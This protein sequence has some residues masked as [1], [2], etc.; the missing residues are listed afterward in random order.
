[1]YNFTYFKIEAPDSILKQD[2]SG[3]CFWGEGTI[4]LIFLSLKS[5]LLKFRLLC[6]V[7]LYERGY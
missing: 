5:L 1:M 3:L 7:L 2:F 6:E 4:H